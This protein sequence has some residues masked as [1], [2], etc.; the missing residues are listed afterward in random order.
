MSAV[1]HAAD[2]VPPEV[3]L[4][5]PPDQCV[6]AWLL[7]LLDAG[8]GH[9]YELRRALAARGVAIELPV[10]Y[11]KLRRLER[12]GWTESRWTSS[13]SGPRRRS[14]ELTSDGRRLL[15][16]AA[17]VVARLRDQND[18]FLDAHS[19]STGGVGR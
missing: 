2:V 15:E 13:L 9:G 7:L 16:E 11:R 17:V 4:P 18:A 3:A 1:A 8:V 14:Y 6:M 12:D 19:R 5:R 10:L